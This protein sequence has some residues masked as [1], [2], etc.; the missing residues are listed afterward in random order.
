MAAWGDAWI[1]A[2]NRSA[3]RALLRLAKAFE[4]E[5]R[6]I[7]FACPLVLHGT[8]GT[9]KSFLAKQL[10]ERIAAFKS[11]PT[12]RMLPCVELPRTADELDE[13]RSCDLLVL[14]D[15]NQLKAPDW[16]ALSGLLDDR[17]A[18]RRP[19]ILT[20]SLGP[21]QLKNL[22]QR[23]TGRLSSGLVLR[24]DPP[25][26]SSRASI[27]RQQAKV[28][29]LHLS[30]DAVAWIAGRIFGLRAIGGAIAQLRKHRKRSAI[31][32]TQPQVLAILGKSAEVAP[33]APVLQGIVSK[34]A[35]LCGRKPSELIGRSRLQAI[36]Q[37]RCIAMHA[38]NRLAG[39]SLVEIGQY[40]GGRNHSTVLSA[41]RKIEAE[42]KKNPAIAAIL[43][44]IQSTDFGR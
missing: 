37:A 38:A 2:E 22:P 44:E 35:K 7:S 36:Q 25:S 16:A 28:A 14:D 41:V 33:L 39:R 24:L 19:T 3:V 10:I 40:F 26:R 21:A 12:A 23:L 13:L 11:H 30:K 17:K 1:V 6:R 20:S 32:M 31:P 18:R 5:S 34:V 8:T 27:V 29:K 15:V 43:R 9:G 42:K 4:T